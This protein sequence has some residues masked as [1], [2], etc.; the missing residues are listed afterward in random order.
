MA[1]L[2]ALAGPAGAAITPSVTLDQSAGT[3]AGGI[4]NLGMDLKFAP[5]GTDSP[6]HMTM[7]LPPGLLANA[8]IDGGAC[9]KTADLSDSA[10]QVGSGTVTADAYGTIPIPTSVTFDLVPPPSAGDLAGLAVNSN[11]TQIGQTAA[12]R[13]RPSGDP[14][15]VGVTLDFVL[16]NSLYGVPI[17]ITEID[18]TFD[19]LR[20]PTTCP[21]TPAP[22]SVSVDSY[23]DSTVKTTTAPLSVTGCSSLPY[24]PKFSV[25]AVRDQHDKQ[26][27]LTTQV[28]QAANESPNR[29]VAL[30]FPLA[31]VEPQVAGLR[32]LCQ[33]VSSGTCTAVGSAT[34]TSPLYPTPLT[35]QAYLTG[36]F[37]GPTLTLVFPSPFPL[38]LTGVVDLVHNSTTFTGLPDIPLTALDVTLNAGTYG[39]FESSCV[40]PAGTATASLTDQNGDRSVKLPA[41]FTV[42]GCPAAPGG[43]TGGSSSGSGSGSGTVS[44]LHA[45]HATLRLTIRVGRHAAALRSLTVRLPRGLV[46]VS[47]RGIRVTGARARSLRVVHG[48]LVVT[49]RR[50]ARSLVVRIASRALRESRSMRSRARRLKHLTV[51]VIARNTRGRRVTIHIRVANRG[52]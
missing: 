18:S 23:S 28:T 4:A 24:A 14:D 26:V 11:G 16:P 43:R 27:K 41:P 46:F 29:S 42:S 31:V 2:A 48:S 3:A 33:N 44:G 12:I 5:T 21:S 10:C 30:A 39:L 34:A 19:G 49:L 20:Y 40:T 47:R 13:V 7:N 6:D 1:A 37:T 38:T 25:T 50:P 36:T 17:S 8:T 52:L 22:V 15:G 45:G 35:G 32:N 51:T 9:L